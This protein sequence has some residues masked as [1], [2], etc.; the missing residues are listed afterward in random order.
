M[1]SEPK[2]ATATTHGLDG[3][4]VL[5]MLVGFFGTVFAVN[6]YFAYA[7]ISTNTGLVAEEPYVKG[8]GYNKRIAASDRQAGLHWTADLGVTT[9]GAVDLMLR[10]AAGEP[11]RGRV[12]ALN[13][14][15]PATERFD[16][17]LVLAEAYPGIYSAATSGLEPGNWVVDAE[18]RSARGG[19]T[20]FR[21]RRRLWLK[22]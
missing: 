8:L 11:V 14:G 13:I 12:V 18:V 22:Q 1:S 2:T 10:D 20:E 16:R 15:R 21:L 4:R 17:A 19:E 6:F 3:R 9:A 7:S 5:M